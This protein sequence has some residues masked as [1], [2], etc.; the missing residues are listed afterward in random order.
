MYIYSTL[1]VGEQTTRRTRH[2]N[3]RQRSWRVPPPHGQYDCLIASLRAYSHFIPIILNLSLSLPPSLSLARACSLSLAHFLS[4]PPLI[5]ELHLLNVF[6]LCFGLHVWHICS[7]LGVRCGLT[8]FQVPPS[9]TPA[10]ALPS[11]S[12]HV[13]SSSL[14]HTTRLGVWGVHVPFE[15]A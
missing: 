12:L 7:S 15:G 5:V 2:F 11:L 14:S 8:C 9:P 1:Q 13:D 10:R 4:T 3:S 6:G